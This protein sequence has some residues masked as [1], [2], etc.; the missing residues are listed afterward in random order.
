MSKYVLPCVLALL[1]GIGLRTAISTDATVRERMREHA[2]KIA[3]ITRNSVDGVSELM[4]GLGKSIETAPRGIAQRQQQ[5][6]VARAAAEPRTG[7]SASQNTEDPVRRAMA[8]I[9]LPGMVGAAFLWNNILGHAEPFPVFAVDSGSKPDALSITF[10][11][12]FWGFI[13]LYIARTM[14]LADGHFGWRATVIPGICL[15]ISGIWEWFEIATKFGQRA[16]GAF[17]NIFGVIANHHRPGNVFL[18]T[19]RL[20]LG[21]P[22]QRPIGIETDKHMITLAETGAG[23]TTGA[24]IPNILLHEG[25]LL[26]IDPKGELAMIT[27]KNR[28]RRFGQDVFVVD[29]S[30]IVDGWTS[31]RYNVFDEI[32]HTSANDTNSAVRF[33]NLIARALVVPSNSSDP[34]WDNA[35]RTFCQGVILY[36]LQEEPKEHHNLVRLRQLLSEGD[37]QAYNG[38]IEEGAL[39]EGAVG[40]LEVLVEEMM[41][42]EAGPFSHIIQGA[43]RSL[44]MMGDK[45]RGAVL[46]VLQEHTS[47]LDSPAIRE[48]STESDFY[49]SELKDRKT[50]VYL[51]LPLGQV[52]G[53]EGRW[54]RMFVMILIEMMMARNQ[55]PNPPVLLAIDEFPSLGK[56]DGIEVVAPVMRS[57]GLRFWAVAQDIDQ[58]KAVYPDAWMTFIGNAEA[59]QFMG[60]KHPE[61]VKLIVSL[62]GQHETVDR[63]QGRPVF[64]ER[65]LLD[66]DQVSRLLARERGNQIVWRGSKKPMLLKIAPYYDYFPPHYYDSDPRFEKPSD[67]SLVD[68]LRRLIA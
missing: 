55:A 46:T 25:S 22:L 49:L 29:P 64:G 31:A 45:Q 56:L 11:L 9:T 34:Y 59:V 51:S 38:L 37:V 54:L 41:A 16:T 10:T 42:V 4:A 5:P 60:I 3:A 14:G 28:A 57:Y 8:I 35:A 20:P 68:M 53:A 13:A 18:G 47:F 40:P 43:G 58:L 6:S 27:A 17:E 32:K 1:A 50:S 61:T 67:G 66:P 2:G 44:S 62:L 36:M 52:K 39:Q 63:R 15:L 33:A 30:H 19:P 23:K 12:L 48:I 26:C 21:I 65:A 7:A 24:L